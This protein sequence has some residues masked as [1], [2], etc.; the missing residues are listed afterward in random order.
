MSYM[1]IFMSSRHWGPDPRLSGSPQAG[2]AH[3][4]CLAP[5]DGYR[6]G[7]SRRSWIGRRR[8]LNF[9]FRLASGRRPTV[10]ANVNQ[11]GPMNTVRLRE[12]NV[13]TGGL[14]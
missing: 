2:D 1:T 13:V 14:A 11:S 4:P 6:P 5:M 10:R 3:R 7:R 9:A 12:A 8:S